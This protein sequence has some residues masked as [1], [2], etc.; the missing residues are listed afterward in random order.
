MNKSVFDSF[1]KKI[2]NSRIDYIISKT[3]RNNHSKI[4]ILTKLDQKSFSEWK[5]CIRDQIFEQ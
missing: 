1:W 4:E 2:V 5:H 3:I